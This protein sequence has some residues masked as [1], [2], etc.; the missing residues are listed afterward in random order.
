MA[1]SSSLSK[2]KPAGLVSLFFSL[3]YRLTVKL[4]VEFLKIGTLLAILIGTAVVSG[5]A[6]I[7]C[8]L[9]AYTTSGGSVLV[10]TCAC[11]GVSG[12]SVAILWLVQVCVKDVLGLTDLTLFELAKLFV[13]AALKNGKRKREPESGCGDEELPE[14]SAPH[15]EDTTSNGVRRQSPRLRKDR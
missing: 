8:I 2:S 5:L 10:A 3:I 11:V 7:Y 15:N 13:S 12:V 1:Q 4:T 6:F 9:W 14:S